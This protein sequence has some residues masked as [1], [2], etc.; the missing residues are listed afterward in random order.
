MLLGVAVLSLGNLPVFTA[1]LTASCA[2][3]VLY[4]NSV[5]GWAPDAVSEEDYDAMS[6]WLNVANLAAAGLFSTVVIVLVRVLPLPAAAVCLALLVFAPTA[7]LLYFPAPRKPE[8]RLKENFAAMATSL[9]RVLKE[10]RVWVGLL[11]FIAPVGAFALTN[12]FSSLGSDFGASERTVT[13]LNG[14]AVAA[15]CGVGCVLAIPL[16]RRFRRRSVYLLAG[17]GASVA[18]GAMGLLPHTVMVYAVGLLAYNFFQG[19]NYTAFTA[20]ELEII[21]P[22]NALSGTMIAMLTAS[23]NIPIS[24]M[25]VIDSKVHDAHGLRA[26]LYTDAWVTV[27]TAAVLMLLVLPLLD[28][29]MRRNAKPLVV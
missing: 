17:L 2:A 3:I 28:S 15:A 6:G 14:L 29:Y 27:A 23:C 9:R 8:G 20:L 24:S 13:G 5:Q 21:G 12:L 18:A 11:I 10:G 22:Q 19:F 25:T 16:C 4:S 7:L 26:M 1:T